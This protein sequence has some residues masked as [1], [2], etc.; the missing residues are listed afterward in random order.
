MSTGT[1]LSLYK[2]FTPVP[3]EFEN[4]IYVIDGEYPLHRVIRR[5]NESFASTYLTIYQNHAVVQ[6]IKSAE[7]HH[8]S[9]KQTCAEASDESSSNGTN[10]IR[11]ICM[12]R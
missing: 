1:K 8:R 2:D 10:K 11:L 7:R 6:S 4:R 9:K 3:T 12:Q 5:R